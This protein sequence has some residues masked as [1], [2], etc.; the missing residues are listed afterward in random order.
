MSCWL[1][2]DTSI[3]YLVK[4]KNYMS[5]ETNTAFSFALIAVMIIVIMFNI[6]SVQDSVD[7]IK[8]QLSYQTIPSCEE[9]ETIE[10]FPFPDGTPSC[11]HREIV[12]CEEA[13]RY[14]EVTGN[15][16]PLFVEFLDCP[17]P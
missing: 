4:E 1:C 6:G 9:D 12:A 16:L 8:E 2:G 10:I 14:E 7:N 11:V 5:H 3:G 17:I 15:N 13:Y